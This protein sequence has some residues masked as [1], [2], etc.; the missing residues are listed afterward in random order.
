MVRNVQRKNRNSVESVYSTTS[1]CK[2]DQIEN[3]IMGANTHQRNV[4]PYNSS[5]ALA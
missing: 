5:M 2:R 3:A 4:G 1:E